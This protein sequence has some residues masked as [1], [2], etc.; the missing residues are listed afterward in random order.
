MRFFIVV[1]P[2]DLFARLHRNDF[3]S[4]VKIFDLDLIVLGIG[5]RDFFFGLA[6]SPA[7]MGR[8]ESNAFGRVKPRMCL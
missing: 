6:Q 2:G 1:N 4:E 3:G 8:V 5:D 7:F